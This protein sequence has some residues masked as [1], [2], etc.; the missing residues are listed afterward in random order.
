MHDH[1]DDLH[2]ENDEDDEDDDD[3]DVQL[4]NLLLPRLIY[5]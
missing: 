4:P 5:K 2:D 1:D 3:G